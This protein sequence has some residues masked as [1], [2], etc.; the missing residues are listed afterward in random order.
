MTILAPA[1]A[2]ELRLM[3]EYA[4][5]LDGPAMIRYPKALCPSEEAPFSLPLERG[6][7]VWLRRSDKSG[8]KSGSRVCLAFTGG[9]YP[10]AL[11]AADRL[12]SQGIAADLY[13]L[14]FL[15]PIDEDY[16]AEILNS[17]DLVVF[18]EEGI[19]CGG[20]GEYAASLARCRACSAQTMILAAEETFSDDGRAIGTREELIK[21][22]ELD[23]DS[24]AEKILVAINL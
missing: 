20:F 2:S 7:G 15:K 3:L 16:L 13:N 5:R 17:Y 22:N 24:I 18:I 8:K 21:E 12:A 19:R 9:L 11:D 10:Q 4:L 14:R 6:R 23:G 1:S